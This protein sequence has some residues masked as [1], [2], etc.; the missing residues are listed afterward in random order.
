MTSDGDARE[1]VQKRGRLP[2]S[3]P[4][5]LGWEEHLKHVCCSIV[6]NSIMAVGGGGKGE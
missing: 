2:S 4:F 3:L 6:G 5:C 1:T